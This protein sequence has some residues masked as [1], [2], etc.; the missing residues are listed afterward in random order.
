[1]TAAQDVVGTLDAVRDRS[2]AQIA[3]YQEIRAVLEN[4]RVTAKSADSSVTVEMA[5][6]GAIVDLRLTPQAMSKTPDTLA[7]TILDTIRQGLA[8]VAERTAAEVEPL[9]G[10]RVDVA[11]IAAGR[12]PALGEQGTPPTAPPVASADAA[13]PAVAPVEAAGAPA[14]DP[15]FPSEED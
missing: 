8:Q 7:S 1:V 9:T 11:S 15:R 12:L 6:G 4:L 10:T 13:A 14:A 3:R 2:R 5:A